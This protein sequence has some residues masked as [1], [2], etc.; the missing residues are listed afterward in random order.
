MIRPPGPLKNRSLGGQT[1]GTK[2]WSGV[3]N[4][5]TSNEESNDLH[6]Q[7][8]AYQKAERKIRFEA[9]GRG[10]EEAEGKKNAKERSGMNKGTNA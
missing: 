7:E 6:A 4:T 5:L 3:R 8:S 1:E 10:S 2:G 9:K